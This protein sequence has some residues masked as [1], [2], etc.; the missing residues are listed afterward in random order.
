MEPSFSLKTCIQGKKAAD[1]FQELNQENLNFGN[2][3]Y[4]IQTDKSE[5]LFAYISSWNLWLLSWDTRMENWKKKK[6]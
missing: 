3:S 1:Q 6:Q 5:Y 4:I 2:L